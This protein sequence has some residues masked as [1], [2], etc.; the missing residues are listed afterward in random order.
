VPNVRGRTI[1]VAVISL[2]AYECVPGK[3][4]R[5]RS[6]NEKKGIV[7]AQ[8]VAPGAQLQAGAKVGLTVGSGAR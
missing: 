3:V 2:R 6:T 7:L 4:A 1:G 8:S 5:R